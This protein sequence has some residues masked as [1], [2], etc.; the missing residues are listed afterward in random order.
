M[1]LNVVPPEVV[2]FANRHDTVSTQVAA[3]SAEGGAVV[4]PLQSAL[5]PAGTIFTA[6]VVRFESNLQVAGKHLARDYRHVAAALR[7]G[8]Q[9]FVTTDED[10]ARLFTAPRPTAPRPGA[11]SL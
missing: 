6:A 11:G 10:S 8:A 5:G 4:G 3:D 9:T 2:K 1:P 7:A